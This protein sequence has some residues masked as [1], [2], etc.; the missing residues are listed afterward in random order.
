[1]VNITT[2]MAALKPEKTKNEVVAQE[3]GASEF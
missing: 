1:L 2:S 3:N